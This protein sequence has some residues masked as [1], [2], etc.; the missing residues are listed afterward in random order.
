MYN[1]I[2]FTPPYCGE[3]N[4]IDHSLIYKLGGYTSMRR[5]SV[6]DSEA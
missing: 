6:R 4:S 5:S 1:T 2:F 3:T